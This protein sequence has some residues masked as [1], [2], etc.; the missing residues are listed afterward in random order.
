M[1]TYRAIQAI[2]FANQVRLS[3]KHLIQADRDCINRHTLT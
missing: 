2:R 1:P 3:T